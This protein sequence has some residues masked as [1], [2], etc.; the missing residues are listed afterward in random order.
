[1]H[2]RKSK[3]GVAVLKSA[4]GAK[5]AG[6]MA[7][8]R[9]WFWQGLALTVLAIPLLSTPALAA[10]DAVMTPAQAA[11]LLKDKG[12]VL[13]MRHAQTVPG[14]GD[15]ANFE[16]GK[17]S[18]QR[19]LSE[20][21]RE[22]ARRIGATL[23]TAGIRFDEV[24]YSEWCRCRETAQLAF[25]DPQPQAWPVLNSFF[26]DRRTEPAQSAALRE[27]ARRWAADK[28]NVFLVTHQVN[29]SAALGTF[30][31]QGEI[32]IARVKADRLVPVGRIAFEPVPQ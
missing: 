23:K 31:R 30:T 20:G 6:R 22:Q 16:L 19:N 32:L 26:E 2:M 25:S 18:T 27:Q 8:L 14:T 21:G 29:I 3:A 28:V 1:M 11:D 12:F 24:R 17:C 4:K 10:A 9:R 7:M 5:Q 13:M 15:P